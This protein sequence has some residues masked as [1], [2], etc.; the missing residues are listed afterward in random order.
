MSI[1]TVGVLA[2]L[3][4]TPKPDDSEEIIYY[5]KEIEYYPEL[6]PYLTELQEYIEEG[7]N[8]AWTKFFQD[9]YN[10]FY[11]EKYNEEG[12]LV[13]DGKNC[14]SLTQ[15]SDFKGM[16]VRFGPIYS[17]DIYV[18]VCIGDFTNNVIN[19]EMLCAEISAYN[20]A[21]PGYA[22]YRYTQWDN[23]NLLEDIYVIQ[24]EASFYAHYM[25]GTVNPEGRLVETVTFQNEDLIN[26]DIMSQSCN[27]DKDG[28]LVLDDLI[29]DIRNTDIR[30]LGESRKEGDI[31]YYKNNA[32]E[33]VP[34]NNDGKIVLYCFDRGE[35]TNIALLTSYNLEA[36]SIEEP[37]C[38]IVTFELLLASEYFNGY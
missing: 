29:Y 30:Y 14:Y 13:F 1:A 38:P 37:F 24:S 4:F 23:S 16:I 5:Q 6:V 27:F 22:R 9:N 35:D 36:D 19:G 33:W 2:T 32:G 26:N 11:N 12:I 18:D 31:T 3:V 8:E 28:K 17:K 10:F 25:Y 20:R 21:L 7:D 15:D 34:L